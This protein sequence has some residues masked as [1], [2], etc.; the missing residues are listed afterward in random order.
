LFSTQLKDRFTAGKVNYFIIN[1]SAILKSNTRALGIPTS[2][3]QEICRG[4]ELNKSLNRKAI[5]HSEP[6]WKIY[7]S[8]GR[9]C[10]NK[11][12]E[13]LVKAFKCLN[14]V[15]NNYELWLIGDGPY[16]NRLKRLISI[17]KLETSEKFLVYR[18]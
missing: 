12:Q 17:L 14:P 10:K 5:I 8:V 16:Y 2:K 13:V 4:S 11:G 6:S 3:V 7:I 18:M 1:S 9:L 15:T